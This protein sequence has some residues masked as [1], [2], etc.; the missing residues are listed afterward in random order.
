LASGIRVNVPDTD[1]LTNCCR[2]RC[3]AIR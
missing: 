2:A 1:F 3:A